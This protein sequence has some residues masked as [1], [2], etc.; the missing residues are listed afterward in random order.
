MSHSKNKTWSS[1]MLMT[2]AAAV[3]LAAGCKQKEDMPD[4]MP[5]PEPARLKLTEV[6]S[7]LTSPLGMA[8][9]D[10]G[11]GRLFIID[12]VGK[13][14]I[15]KR[16]GTLVATPFLDLTSKMVA[17][18]AAYDERGLLGLAFHPDYAANGYLYVYYSA[19]LRAG[20]PVDYNCTSTISRFTV[21]TGNPDTADLAS[22]KII[23]QVDKPQFNHNGGQL[24]FGKDGFLYISLGDGGGANDTGIGHPALGNG[25]DATTLLGSI[26]RID[27]DLGDPYT[28]PGDNPF[29][30]FAGFQKEI[31]AFGFRNPWRMSFDSMDGRLF[32]GDVGQ[33]LWEEVDIVTSGANYGWNR[34]EGKHFFTR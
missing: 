34:M 33:N 7:G 28:I 12:Q 18:T 32:V 24:L 22:E 21:T 9:P 16:D 29:V 13:I 14:R 31:Y 1:W 8:W 30:F 20:A 6:A 25:Q 2:A 5:V 19:P 26:L 15:L 23:L 4:A 17:L 27:V 11:T 10:D 3:L